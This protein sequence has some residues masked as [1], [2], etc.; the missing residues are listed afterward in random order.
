[1]ADLFRL[2]KPGHQRRSAGCDGAGLRENYR[3]A[4]RRARLRSHRLRRPRPRT[5]RPCRCRRGHDPVRTGSALSMPPC[6]APSALMRA[7][8][9]AEDFH[10]RFAARGKIYRYL[11]R[12]GPVLP[13]HEVGRVWHFPQDL[14]FATFTQAASDFCR[15]GTISPPLP[16]TAAAPPSKIPTGPSIGSLR[17][18]RGEPVERDL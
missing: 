16:P 8:K 13:P 11:I 18:G 15:A 2:A 4:R 17:P 1:M 5:I 6:R 12:N 10:A 14:D 3:F 7:R 9:A